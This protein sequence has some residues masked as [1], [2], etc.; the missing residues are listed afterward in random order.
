MA[1]TFEMFYYF[2]N[3]RLEGE[4]IPKLWL[5]K[6]FSRFYQWSISPIET[7]LKNCIL[8]PKGS[9]L[10][11]L[12]LGVDLNWFHSSLPLRVKRRGIGSPLSTSCSN[13]SLLLPLLP[14]FPPNSPLATGISFLPDLIPR[15]HIRLLLHYFHVRASSLLKSIL[16][17]HFI[18]LLMITYNLIQL[19]HPLFPGYTWVI[20]PS[21]HYSRFTDHLVYEAA[22]I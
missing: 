11:Q 15:S 19:F 8:D 20:F 4:P 12:C 7:P 16:S 1:V 13:Q 14:D 10:V 6:Q 5:L 18:S 2:H 3:K 17:V 21:T 22:L 9:P